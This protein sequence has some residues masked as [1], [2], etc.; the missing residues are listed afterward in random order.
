MSFF[1]NQHYPA[2]QATPSIRSLGIVETKESIDAWFNQLR[3]FVRAI[4][5]YQRYMDIKWTSHAE[6]MTR[7]FV[8]KTENNITHA[9]TIQ[10][11]PQE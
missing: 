8:D 7:G 5:S 11:S 6:S 1:P 9:N 10:S 4:P 3:A 2:M